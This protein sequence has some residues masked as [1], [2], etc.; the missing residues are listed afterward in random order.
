ML[1]GKVEI[2]LK[3]KSIKRT[4]SFTSN[5]KSNMSTVSYLDL[6]LGPDCKDSMVHD[7]ENLKE[8]GLLM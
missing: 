4:I 8:K 2:L 3:I 6:A 5:T 1:K 7:K